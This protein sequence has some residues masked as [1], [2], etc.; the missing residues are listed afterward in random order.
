[1]KSEAGT[2][3][4]VIAINSLGAAFVPFGLQIRAGCAGPGP[5]RQHR[6]VLPAGTQPVVPPGWLVTASPGASMRR[7]EFSR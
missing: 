5:R 3:I 4:D 2:E 1:M 6:A 7:K